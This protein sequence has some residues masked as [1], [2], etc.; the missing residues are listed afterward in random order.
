M[1]PNSQIL[2]INQGV[3]QI[4]VDNRQISANDF[5]SGGILLGSVFDDHIVINNA[6]TPSDGDIR[7]LFFFHRQRKRAQ[8]I[9]HNAFSESSGK[10]IY[11]GEWHTHSQKIPTPSFKD[12]CEIKRAFKK[13]K[14]NLSFIILII[15]GY[16]NRMGNIWLGFQDTYGLKKCSPLI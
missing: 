13:S 2:L 5:E 4:F 1:L 11:I 8:K 12:R 15:V 3:L 9:I 6:T 10:Q 16:D 7:G 14:T